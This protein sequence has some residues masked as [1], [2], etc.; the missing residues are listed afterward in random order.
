MKPKP[1][2]IPCVV[3]FCGRTTKDDG[4]FAHWICGIHWRLVDRDRRSRLNR[5]R[6][7]IR[8]AFRSQGDQHPAMPYL[9]RMDARIWEKA[10]LQAIERAV[11]I[12]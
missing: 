8:K 4:R 12:A 7:L 9:R 6:R 2:R 1:G 5:C 10:R 11:G 3:P